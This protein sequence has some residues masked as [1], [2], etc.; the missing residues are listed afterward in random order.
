MTQTYANMN[1]GDLLTA[2]GDDA[3]KWADAF[4]EQYPAMERAIM[5]GWFANAIEHSGDVR[6]GRFIQD[7]ERWTDFQ[8]GV[9]RDRAFWRELKA[10]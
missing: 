8:E 9:E 5:F 4:C 7:D 2:L 6:R 1:D 10:A 3:T